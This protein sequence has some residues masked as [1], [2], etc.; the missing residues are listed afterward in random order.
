MKKVAIIGSLAIILIVGIYGISKSVDSGGNKESKNKVTG[1]G[2]AKENEQKEE[3]KHHYK[4]VYVDELFINIK[5]LKSEDELA[6]LRDDI[7]LEEIQ[8]IEPGTMTEEDVIEKLGIQHGMW[9]SGFCYYI[10]FTKDNHIAGILYNYDGEDPVVESVSI[11]E[12]DK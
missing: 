5:S 3:S 8:S 10:Y 11:E 4:G 7:S 1:V 12:W 2:E 9:G 6:P